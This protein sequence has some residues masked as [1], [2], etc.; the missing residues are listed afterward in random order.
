[1]KSIVFCATKGG[2]GKTALTANLGAIIASRSH[3][4]LLVDAGPQPSH[5]SFYQLL[6]SSGKTGLTELLTSPHIPEPAQTTIEGLNIIPSDDPQG[7]LEHQLLHIPDG[8]LRMLQALE[9]VQDYDVTRYNTLQQ[10]FSA[11]IYVK[12]NPQNELLW[13]CFST[14]DGVWYGYLLDPELLGI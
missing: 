12:M 11:T 14:S 3:R 9:T 13:K 5:S 8:R 10:D 4:V 6:E 2:V 7:S 1:M